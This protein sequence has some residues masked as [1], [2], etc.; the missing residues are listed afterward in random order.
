[1]P[2]IAES[3]V[4]TASFRGD[5]RCRE[6]RHSAPVQASLGYPNASG[7]Q[8]RLILRPIKA[9]VCKEFRRNGM[10]HVFVVVLVTPISPEH[11]IL[12]DGQLHRERTTSEVST[13]RTYVDRYA[14]RWRIAR[15]QPEKPVDRVP[16]LPPDVRVR[17]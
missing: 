9:H 2:D 12:L 14:A 5:E 4:S 16:T 10:N 15:F 7:L 8:R 3:G 1:M 13:F 17:V 11:R 6:G